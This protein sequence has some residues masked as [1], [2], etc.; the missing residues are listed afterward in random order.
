MVK[1]TRFLYNF[2]I[3]FLLLY[4][5]F[6]AVDFYFLKKLVVDLSFAILRLLNSSVTV[7]DL[8]ILSPD[9]SFTIVTSCTGIVSFSIFSGLIYA[10]PIKSPRRKL[11]YILLSFPIFFCWN[12]MR[13]VMT[14][15]VGGRLVYFFHNFFWMFSV[16][17]I[18]FLYFLVMRREEV[19][20]GKVECPVCGKEFETLDELHHHE[21]EHKKKKE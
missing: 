12:V 5:F 7:E 13:V 9:V 1:L 11:L 8:T 4:I 6:H 16:G 20:L 3:V 19:Y 14:L 15:C 18:L 10:T 17:I 2:F 21:E